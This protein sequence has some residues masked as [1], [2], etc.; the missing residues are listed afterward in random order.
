MSSYSPAHEV[1]MGYTGVMHLVGLLD[2]DKEFFSRIAM[3]FAEHDEY[4]L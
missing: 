2:C 3:E 4:Q 1:Q